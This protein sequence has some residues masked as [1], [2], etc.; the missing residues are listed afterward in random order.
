M[1]LSIDNVSSPSFDRRI[2]LRDWDITNKADLV[3]ALDL[4]EIDE[5]DN[6]YEVMP[7]A[8]GQ[9]WDED[10]LDNTGIGM[11]RMWIVLAAVAIGLIGALLLLTAVRDIIIKPS[12]TAVVPVSAHT[13]APV[14]SPSITPMPSLPPT[15]FPVA[16]SAAPTVWASNSTRATSGTPLNQPVVTPIST[17]TPTTTP[18]PTPVPTIDPTPDPMPDP[19]VDPIPDPTPDPT[20][21]PTADPT[22]D[23]TSDQNQSSTTICTGDTCL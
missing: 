12:S 21:D 5:A 22:V 3:N 15:V 23:P 18:M 4:R 10:E 16:S 2:D 17:P 8:Y 19:T 14:P 1:K 20:S 13:T 6:F 7:V 11:Q 9:Q